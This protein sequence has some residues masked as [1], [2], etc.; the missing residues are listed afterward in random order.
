MGAG[1]LARWH[2]DR[3]MAEI[4]AIRYVA[5][6]LAELPS[7]VL[8]PPRNDNF[9]QRQPPS[10]HH[11]RFRPRPGFQVLDEIELA[12]FAARPCR[13]HFGGPPPSRD[14]DVAVRNEDRS[15]K[16]NPSERHSRIDIEPRVRL[17]AARRC[18]E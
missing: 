12:P 18:A 13:Q 15:E 4:E 14:D 16:R 7:D 11:A 1:A 5:G 10:R 6:I 17:P 3:K 8:Q 2:I 9:P